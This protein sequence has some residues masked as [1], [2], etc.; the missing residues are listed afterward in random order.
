MEVLRVEDL[1]VKVEGR[2]VL[3]GVNFSI[4]EREKV[5]IVGDN[6]SGKTTL[7]ETIMGFI[8]PDRGR[9]LF[10]GKELKGEEDFNQ[11]RRKIGY[12]FQ[13]P[14][15]QLFCPTVEEEIAF[16]PLA[17]GKK[18]EEVEEIVKE[19]LKTFQIEH[20]RERPTHKLSG[21][22]KRIVSVAAVLSMDPEVLI[23]D[24]PTLGLDR[25]RF[26]ILSSF[27][28]ETEI[29]VLL[30]THEKELIE[31]LGWRVVRIEGP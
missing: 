15:E 7:A 23:L 10:K 3:K 20:L 21:G 18:R 17:L 8:R 28:K 14:D 13:N 11:I 12:C 6:G 24:E 1:W 16:A 30:I 2:E 4:K 19:L 27:L 9:I 25:K 26:Q 31:H 22:E 5:L 29:P